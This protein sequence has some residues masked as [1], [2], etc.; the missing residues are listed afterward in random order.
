LRLDVYITLLKFNFSSV[1]LGL[2]NASK[3][4]SRKSYDKH[5]ISVLEIIA[6]YIA[7]LYYN[8]FYGEAQ[9]LKVDKKVASVTDGY[10][11]AVK[12]YITSLKKPEY[13]RRSITGIHSYYQ[14]TTKFTSISMKECINDIVRQFAPDEY[15]SAMDNRQKEVILHNVLIDSVNNFSNEVLC[16]PLLMNIIDN[17]KDPST[18][19]SIKQKMVDC[20][21]F[22]R[23]KVYRR[24]FSSLVD[25]KKQKSGTD[26][27]VSA[28]MKVELTKMV[29]LNGSLSKRVDALAEAVDDAK[30]II[31]E[32][33][34][35]I[36][37]FKVA[38][39][40][41]HEKLLAAQNRPPAADIVIREPALPVGQSLFRQQ[42]TET[43]FNAPSL[44]RSPAPELSSS[45]P[46]SMPELE[47]S[48]P[49]T[50]VEQDDEFES[51]SVPL[52]IEKI[53]P[54]AGEF[55]AGSLID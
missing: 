25:P 42:Q 29:K 37:Q 23:E 1:N 16:G 52:A 31:K 30:K 48:P 28:Q 41:T 24:F 6:A 40:S 18:A 34:K 4:F 33:N 19:V 5:T 11:H 17:H 35:M 8:H 20:L 15:F 10:T 36:A 7:N 55:F 54:D 21:L 45:E 51:L 39:R 53:E 46:E 49:L 43:D 12:A 27:K 22:E 13:Y 38:L 32:K 26:M 9:R 50:M 2:I 47:Q 14:T 44:E 3:M